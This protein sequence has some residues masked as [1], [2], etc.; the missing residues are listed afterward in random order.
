MRLAD[1]E[2]RQKLIMKGISFMKTCITYILRRIKHFFRWLIDTLYFL[3]IKFVS[4]SPIL[5]SGG[6]IILLKKNMINW[7]STITTA[8]F[9]ISIYTL[10]ITRTNR[11]DSNR[12]MLNE[13]LI[14]VNSFISAFDNI[15]KPNMKIT[16]QN[17]KY[18]NQL[19]NLH[20][21]PMLEGT[22]Y[23]ENMNEKL[24]NQ[25]FQDY[26]SQYSNRSSN[27]V[28][29]IEYADKKILQLL[30][31]LYEKT[32]NY[33]TNFANCKD[34][35]N[36]EYEDLKDLVKREIKISRNISGLKRNKPDSKDKSKN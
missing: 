25:E 27:N 1:I 15:S 2:I 16:E 14:P 9:I 8:S 34:T 13:F 6:L 19:Y 31:N 17:V 22:R 24:K 10:Q 18:F 29:I 11:L 3:S 12:F 21:M 20:I 28:V 23:D 4:F 32:H 35:I 33:E 5:L 36:Y 26:I 7:E 30:T